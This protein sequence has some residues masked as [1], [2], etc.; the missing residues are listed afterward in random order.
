MQ[1][2]RL[3][4]R[5]VGFAATLTLLF[6][7]GAAAADTESPEEDNSRN[8]FYM[9]INVMGAFPMTDGGQFV[10]SPDEGFLVPDPCCDYSDTRTQPSYGINARVGWRILRYLAAELQYEWVPEIETKLQGAA[11]GKT[12]ARA[13]TANLRL[14]APFSS[15][16]PYLLTGVGFMWYENTTFPLEIDNTN[17]NRPVPP[18]IVQE[19]SVESGKEFAARLGAG[20]DMYITH[21]LVANLEISGVLSNRKILDERWPYISV[22]GG[23]QYRF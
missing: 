12:K 21:H 22:S 11:I 8:G 4:K 7:L 1:F 23:L 3:Q 18:D 9:G 16:Q 17:P 14:I 2:A 6:G 19:Q 10:P 15:L 5:L 13:Y 20:L